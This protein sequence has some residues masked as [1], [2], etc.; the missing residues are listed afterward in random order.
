MRLTPASFALALLPSA[1]RG[2][3]DPVAD[4]AAAAIRKLDLQR[5]IPHE[6]QVAPD[7]AFWDFRLPPELLWLLGALAL[8]L[9]LY[10]LR[11]MIPGLRRE[12][13]DDWADAAIG[14][15]QAAPGAGASLAAADDLAGQG[16][17]VE[18]MHLLLLYSLTELRRRLRVE[19][20]DSLTSREI[21]RAA[22]LPDAGRA[23]LDGIVARV[24][25]SYFG[26]H[27]AEAIDYQSCRIRFV[28]LRGVLE[29]TPA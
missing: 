13:A 1:A 18:A 26:D 5:E 12:D 22:R 19:F 27:P 8:L 23:A 21:L 14:G 11:D 6:T 24:E 28:A 10:V 4:A 7:S 15:A 16:R 3:N 17:F 29:G 25:A 9:V 2:R 20:A